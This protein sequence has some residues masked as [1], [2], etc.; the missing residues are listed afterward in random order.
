M[1]NREAWVIVHHW[2]PGMDTLQAVAWSE[3]EAI[4]RWEEQ[5]RRFPLTRVLIRYWDGRIFQ[6]RTPTAPQYFAK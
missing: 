1:E 3:E 2:D 6:D 5:R 4:A